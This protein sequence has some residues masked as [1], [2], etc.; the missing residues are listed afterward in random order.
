M[1]GI[2][3]PDAARRISFDVTIP[4]D[5]AAGEHEPQLVGDNPSG[6]AHQTWCG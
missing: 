4:H 6:G 5:V 2:G 1:L 3:S